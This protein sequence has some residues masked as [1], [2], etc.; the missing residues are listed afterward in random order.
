MAVQRIFW[1]DMDFPFHEDMCGRILWLPRAGPVS[2]P[3]LPF[4]QKW[5][6]GFHL[7]G[8]RI[9]RLEHARPPL[10]RLWP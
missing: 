4:N 7:K 9:P 5:E 1:F 2:D 10:V 3:V 6:R 8:E